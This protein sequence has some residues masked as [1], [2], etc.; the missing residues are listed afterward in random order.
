M[1]ALFQDVSDWAPDGNSLILGVLGDKSNQGDDTS[2][3]LWTVP[4]TGGGVPAPYVR[5]TAVERHARISPDG[6]WLLYTTIDSGQLEIFVDSYPVPGHRL[7]VLSAEP[8]RTLRLLWGRGSREVLYSDSHGDLIS[9]PVEPVGDELRPGEPTRLFTLPEGLIGITS[10][11]GER[12]LVS[13]PSGATPGPS[14]QITL[15]WTGLLKK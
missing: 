3:D 12:F 1:S 4:L 7:Q 10:R 5:S 2:W 11:D 13:R 8:D 14:L 9:L 15:G 6:R